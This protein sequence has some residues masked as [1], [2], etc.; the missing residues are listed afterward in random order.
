MRRALLIAALAIASACGKKATDKPPETIG[1]TTYDPGQPVTFAFDSLDARPVD[2]ASL[3]G[4]PTIIAFVATWDLA[5]QA[6]IDFMV[7][8]SK[9]DG[10]QVNYVMVAL[11]E[12][13]DR[14]LV[15]AFRAGLHVDFPVALGDKDS[16]AGGGPLGDVHNVPTVLILDR[17]GRVVS[18][19]VGLSRADELRA[20]LRGL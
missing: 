1:Q 11:Q 14:E 18:K 8:M 4:K 17:A 7:P 19:R 13:K 15:D 20:G 12:P 9:H 10:A 2:S 3:R 16:I 6:Q 5:S